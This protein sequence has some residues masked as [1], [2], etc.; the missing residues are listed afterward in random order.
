MKVEGK[1]KVCSLRQQSLALERD[2]WTDGVTVPGRTG[3]TKFLAGPL[4][5]VCHSDLKWIKF[6]RDDEKL[7]E[8]SFSTSLPK[9]SYS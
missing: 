9:V 5:S 7:E 8:T 2:R 1:R 4:Y 3:K 6:F